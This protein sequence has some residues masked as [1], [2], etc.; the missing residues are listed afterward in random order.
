[1]GVVKEVEKQDYVSTTDGD[2]KA[3]A[4]K[5]DSVGNAWSKELGK[6]GFDW[7]KDQGH[8]KHGWKNVYHKEEWGDSKK[9]HDIFHD[10]DWK[11]KWNNWNREK[12]RLQKERSHKSRHKETEGAKKNQK[13]VRKEQRKKGKHEMGS[14]LKSRFR[15]D[16]E[17][18]V[19]ETKEN[20]KD[21]KKDTKNKTEDEEAIDDD[22]SHDDDHEYKASKR[23]VYQPRSRVT[24]GPPANHAVHPHDPPDHTNAILTNEEVTETRIPRTRK[25]DLKKRRN[26]SQKPDASS[27]SPS[28]RKNID[29]AAKSG[30]RAHATHP[31]PRRSKQRVQDQGVGS[32]GM[33]HDSGV[34]GQKQ[35]DKRKSNSNL[36]MNQTG[37]QA[38]SGRRNHHPDELSG[39]TRGGRGQRKTRRKLRRRFPDSEEESHQEDVRGNEEKVEAQEA[40]EGEDGRG[41][42]MEDEDDDEEE[43]E[44]K[45]E[46]N[47]LKRHSVSS[48]LRVL[49]DDHTVVVSPSDS[50]SPSDPRQ[51]SPHAPT[52]LRLPFTPPHDF[53]SFTNDQRLQHDG[54]WFPHSSPSLFQVLYPGLVF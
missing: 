23:V 4:E 19:R 1:M 38:P 7:F 2:G 9:Y 12:E 24:D 54:H 51:N 47:P 46:Q 52:S 43:E 11:K 3:T 5:G 10:R 21:K 17:K 29:S 15:K 41:D 32:R 53:K 18:G 42:Q 25:K 33:I 40:D 6:L 45:E 48:S 44:G 35:Q 49:P 20:M 30:S 28:E 8:K 50:S 14:H 37:V 31:E 27:D 36:R 22:S 13:A 39:S 16:Q 26:G 34:A